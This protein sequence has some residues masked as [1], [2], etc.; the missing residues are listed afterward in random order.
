M[1]RFFFLPKLNRKRLN[2]HPG[3]VWLSWFGSWLW[4][5]RPGFKSW[6]PPWQYRLCFKPMQWSWERRSTKWSTTSTG[7][8][9]QTGGSLTVAHEVVSSIPHSHQLKL[10]SCCSDR[11]RELK[12]QT[13][14][15]I[16]KWP[17][18]LHKDNFA[19]IRVQWKLSGYFLRSIDVI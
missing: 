13:R 12:M 14:L 5:W 6:C 10:F 7:P 9:A 19:K 16:R 1:W 4:C 8:V 17:S 15:R 11:V 3:L 18:R 2:L